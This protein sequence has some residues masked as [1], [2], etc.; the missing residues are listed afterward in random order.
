[1]WPHYYTHHAA[2]NLDTVTVGGFHFWDAQ[3][4]LLLT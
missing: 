4:P 1:M 3:F 2:E